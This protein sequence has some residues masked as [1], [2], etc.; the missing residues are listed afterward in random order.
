MGAKAGRSMLLT[1]MSRLGEVEVRSEYLTKVG[2]ANVSGYTYSDGSIAV[3]EVPE[4]VD[5]VIHELLHS[6]HP[7]Y[8]EITVRRLT[9]R[10]MHQMTDAEVIAFYTA[11]RRKVGLPDGLA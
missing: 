9:R 7:D 11:Y 4:V 6:V 10:L 3:N 5:T 2:S 8:S 1:L